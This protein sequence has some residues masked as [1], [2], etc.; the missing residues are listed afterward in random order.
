MELLRK[1]DHRQ[2][3]II[4]SKSQKFIPFRTKP[5]RSTKDLITT[6]KELNDLKIS[7]KALNGVNFDYGTAEGKLFSTILAAFAQFERELI[8]ERI[9]S[10]LAL[11]KSKGIILGRKKGQNIKT[12]EIFNDILLDWKSGM[13]QRKIA[14][15]YNLGLTTI[16][17]M[18]KKFKE[19]KA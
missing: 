9:K 17:M 11:A 18:V 2:N 1:T 16:V 13:P 10:G 12:G 19:S 3:T 5:G 15:K 4:L 14:E 6:L 8:Q 7:L